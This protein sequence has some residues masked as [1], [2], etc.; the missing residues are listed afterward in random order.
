MRV[1]SLFGSSKQRVLLVLRNS[2]AGVLLGR[3]GLLLRGRRDAGVVGGLGGRGLL[4]RL[5]FREELLGLEGGD[6]AGACSCQPLLDVSWE[7]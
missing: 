4:L 6:T 5:G 3:G 1:S 7:D 2:L